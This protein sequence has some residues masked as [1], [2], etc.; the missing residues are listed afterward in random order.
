MTRDAI[1]RRTNV[2]LEKINRAIEELEKPDSSSRSKTYGG[3]RIVRLDD[4]RDWGWQIVNYLI[5]RDIASE[6]QRREKTR[7]RVHKHRQRK[8]LKECN[9]PVTPCTEN[10]ASNAMQK[11]RQ[12]HKQKEK[13]R[14]REDARARTHAREE[15]KQSQTEA[16][17]SVEEVIAHGDSVGVPGEYCRQYFL[18]KEIKGTWKHQ[19]RVVNWRVELGMWWEQDQVVWGERRAQGNGDGDGW[20]TAAAQAAELRGRLAMMPN[21]PEEEKTRLKE[22]LAVLER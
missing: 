21:M 12:M 17:P 5:Y 2:P 6:E 7:T 13:Q 4:H 8:R 20:G 22:R 15:I 10:N 16:V 3:A 14:E 18:K 1:A 19:G 11:Q 9:A